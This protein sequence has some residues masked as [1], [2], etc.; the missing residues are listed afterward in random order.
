MKRALLAATFVLS[1][2]GLD[3]AVL[4]GR[5]LDAQSHPVARATVSLGTSFKD[6]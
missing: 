1:S 6:A 2:S 4:Y 3:A 5:V